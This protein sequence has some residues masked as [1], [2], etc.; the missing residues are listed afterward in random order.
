MDLL[1]DTQTGRLPQRK[2]LQ[3]A[4]NPPKKAEFQPAQL[5]KLAHNQHNLSLQHGEV[6][7]S[8]TAPLAQHSSNTKILLVHMDDT[9]AWRLLLSRRL[10]QLSH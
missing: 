10:C 6:L 9:C 3:T 7:E 5:S 4:E 8:G 1:P 2:L